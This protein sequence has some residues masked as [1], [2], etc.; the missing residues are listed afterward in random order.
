MRRARGA[1][2]GALSGG[3]WGLHVREMGVRPVARAALG[4]AT[5]PVT[6]FEMNNVDL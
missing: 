1:A 4:G 5:C 6:R 3:L 2:A